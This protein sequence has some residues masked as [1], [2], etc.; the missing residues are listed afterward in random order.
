MS[1][2]LQVCM[3]VCLWAR[4]TEKVT[5]TSR[6]S[7]RCARPLCCRSAVCAGTQPDVEEDDDEEED[8]DED[9]DELWAADLAIALA[10]ALATA[11]GLTV[12]QAS[13]GPFAPAARD[14]R[15]LPRPLSVGEAAGK[16]ARLK[17]FLEEPKESGNG[18]PC[19]RARFRPLP[20]PLAASLSDSCG[21]MWRLCRMASRTAAS[22]PK[23]SGRR[24]GRDL[25]PTQENQ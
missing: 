24:F 2:C 21:C 20:P 14:A 16:A 22:S 6:R 9:D 8:E 12:A 5:T 15:A 18:E 4:C 25:R 3:S 11:A 13:R 7:F 19:A 23:S 1:T 17:A 10:A